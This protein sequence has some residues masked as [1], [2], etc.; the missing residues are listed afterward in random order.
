M[1]GHYAVLPIPDIE[2]TRH[3]LVIGANPAV[4]NGSLMTAPA[5]R[6]K[7]KTI[8]ARGGKV[9]V[10]DPR[11]TETARHASEHVAV[12][13]GGRP[14]PAAGDAERDLRRGPGAPRPP[15]RPLRRPRPTCALSPGS[16]RPERAAA[17][18]GVEAGEIER[19]AREFAAAP[20]AVAYGRVG[21]CHQQTGIAHPLA[22]QR[23]Q[24]VTGNMDNVGGAMFPKPAVDLVT[25]SER[26][27]GKGGLGSPTTSA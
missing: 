1:F 17:H 11:R 2:R 23:P 3:L 5:V 12:R 16:G 9:V 7:I 19:L 13:P 18:A 10:V 6:E 22:D 27:I 20:S 24:P 8:R 21:V 4:S 15:G 26:L 14:L 25:L